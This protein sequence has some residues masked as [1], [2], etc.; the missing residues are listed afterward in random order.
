[1]NP[2]RSI[3]SAKFRGTITRGDPD[4]LEPGIGGFVT[5]ALY[6]INFVVSKRKAE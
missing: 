3:P 1:M 6:S 5:E 2:M 4:K